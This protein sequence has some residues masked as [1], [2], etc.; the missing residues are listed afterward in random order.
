MGDLSRPV[1]CVFTRSPTCRVQKILQVPSREAGVPVQGNALRTGLSPS[2]LHPYRSRCKSDSGK[3]GGCGS[4][5]PGRLFE[6]SRLCSKGD[7]IDTKAGGCVAQAGI[8]GEHTKVGVNPFTNFQVCGVWLQPAGRGSI[9][10]PGPGTGHCCQGNSS[11]AA[12]TNNSGT[13][14]VLPGAACSHREDGALGQAAYAAPPTHVKSTLAVSTASE[15]QDT[16]QPDRNFG[17]VGKSR[18]YSQKSTASQT[19]PGSN[20]VHRCFDEGLGGP[21]TAPHSQR[22][23]VSHGRFLAHKRTRAKSSLFGTKKVP[24]VGKREGSTGS[25]GQFHSTSPYKQTGGNQVIPNAGEDLGAPTVVSQPKHHVTSP[26]HSGRE[27]RDCGRPVQDTSSVTDRVDAAQSNLSSV[28]QEVGNPR[29]GLVCHKIQQSASTIH[30]ATTRLAGSSS[31]RHVSVVDGEIRLC[32]S[33]VRDDEQGGAKSSSGQA[34]AS[35][36]RSTVAPSVVVP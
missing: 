22:P 14:F 9:P 30:I 24:P 31:G 25:D 4:H 12:A 7:R 34:T 16:H 35:V 28:V 21:F 8:C 15:Y 5:L 27:E 19:L 2:H 20:C 1:R 17:L 29:V 6:Q 36:D 32:V 26:A 18:K 3:P 13:A 10:L 11:E 23:V 33:P